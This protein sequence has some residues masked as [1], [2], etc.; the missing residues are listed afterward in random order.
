MD[1]QALLACLCGGP[2]DKIVVP[3][4]T[5][6]YRDDPKLSAI[7]CEK[8]ALQSP[9]S[10]NPHH[11]VECNR[12]KPTNWAEAM[13]PLA[14]FSVPAH[15]GEPNPD[16]VSPS[17]IVSI[18]NKAD[19]ETVKSLV[20]AFLTDILS[21]RPR[22]PGLTVQLP[23]AVYA[24]PELGDKETPGLIVATSI[25]SRIAEH[26]LHTLVAVLMKDEKTTWGVLFNEIY[27]CA[28]DLAK[29][30]LHELWKYAEEHPYEVAA[31]V[32]LTVLAMGVMARMLPALLRVLGFAELGPVEGECFLFSLSLF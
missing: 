24:H 29:E 10:S 16:S 20:T 15:A 3:Y 17:S 18:N 11:H 7:I 19:D 13:I 22:Q 21:T 32:L 14:K 2:I 27:N 8:P 9:P 1:L 6:E 26:V 12:V 30:E 4:R 5:Q 31:E 25:A 28:V 23:E